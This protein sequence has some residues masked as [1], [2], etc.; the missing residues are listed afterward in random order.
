[1]HGLVHLPSDVLRFG[2]LDMFSCFSFENYLY[3]LKKLIRHSQNPLVQLVKRLTEA[4]SSISPLLAHLS[5]TRFHNV[6]VLTRP[7][8]NGPLPDGQELFRAQEFQSAHY[9]HWNLSTFHP[10]RYVLLDDEFKSVVAIENFIEDLDG[11]VYII[12]RSYQNQNPLF[13]AP[14]D[15]CEILSIQCV[16][17]PSPLL[18]RWPIEKIKTKAFAMRMVSQE[19]DVEECDDHGTR[20]AVFPLFMQDK[21]L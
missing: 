9:L 4:T 5:K 2:P 10:N 11:S 19:G 16:Y 15:S 21:Y 3:T 1:M 6:P 17:Q 14:C 13:Q 12:G 8:S 20:L 18:C 7:H